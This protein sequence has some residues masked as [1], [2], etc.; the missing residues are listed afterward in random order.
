MAQTGCAHSAHGR[1]TPH[2]GHPT[3]GVRLCAVSGVQRN[4]GDS[5]NRFGLTAPPSSD[6]LDS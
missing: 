2:I 3:W 1:K 5:G 4:V 6:D